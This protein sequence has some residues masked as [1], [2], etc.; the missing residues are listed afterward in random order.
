[1][2]DICIE[3]QQIADKRGLVAHGFGVTI[4][5]YM[6]F[7]R[8]SLEGKQIDARPILSAI[9]HGCEHVMAQGRNTG[10][11]GGGVSGVPH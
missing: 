7:R 11:A 10:Y 2:D 8:W 3:A 1:M 4:L 6:V 9:P 5:S